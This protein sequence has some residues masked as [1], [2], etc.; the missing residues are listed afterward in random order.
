MSPHLAGSPGRHGRSPLR[1]LRNLAAA[2]AYGF[3]TLSAAPAADA[4]ATAVSDVVLARAALAALDA[5]SQL[6]D[7]NL[8]V[9]VVN[10][11]AVIGGPVASAETGKR[12]AA[13]IRRVEGIA[14]V[15]N[16]CFVQPGL[17]PLLLA[18]ASHSP[19]SPRRV[20]ATELPGI[21][22]SP[23][24]GVVEEVLPSPGENSFAAVAPA[25]KTV[26]ARRPASPGESVLLPPVGASGTIPLGVAPIAPPAPSAIL[27]SVPPAA[28]AG[29]GADALGAAEML[30]KSE[31]RF[32]GLTL[33]LREGTIVIAGKAVR[34]A[35]TW[36]LAQE[37][38]RI[39]G[40]SRVA[41]GALE[42]R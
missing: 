15:K 2:V 29:R 36:D 7:V 1:I 19:S 24:T 13:I 25:E 33:T 21:V 14:D 11:V 9:S 31:Q 41:V 34:A 40:V 32:A 20:A 26:V 30:R 38:R 6:K 12:A 4:S 18:L 37:L 16:H 42:M 35:D 17:D 8:L 10:R 27:T 28:S 39:P 5:D 3:M 22:A 23:K